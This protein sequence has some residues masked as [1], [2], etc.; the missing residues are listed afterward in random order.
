MP[1]DFVHGG[2]DIPGGFD[3]FGDWVDLA[4]V[5]LINGV[6]VSTSDRRDI[7]LDSEKLTIGNTGYRH[8][9]LRIN[10]KQ[11]NLSYDGTLPMPFQIQPVINNS[12]YSELLAT[13]SLPP[14]SGVSTFSFGSFGDFTY[15]FTL[16][17]DKDDTVHMRARTV[18]RTTIKGQAA[19]GPGVTFL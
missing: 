8:F 17:L 4:F 12:P 18:G 13:F 14:R 5:G 7:S 6:S 10:A 11:F 15:S 3:G 9:V 1:Y 2:S 16:D 19:V